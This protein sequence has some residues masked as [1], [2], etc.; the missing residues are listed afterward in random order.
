EKRRELPILDGE[1]REACCGQLGLERLC[2]RRALAEARHRTRKVE[3]RAAPLDAGEGKYILGP[4]LGRDRNS[5]VE[6][7]GRLDTGLQI[8]AELLEPVPREDP[9]TGLFEP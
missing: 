9:A 6:R 3:P 7:V 1:R 8:G 4:R 2:G 5:R